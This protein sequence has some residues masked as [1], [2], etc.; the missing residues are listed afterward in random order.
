M[1]GYTNEKQNPPSLHDTEST[2]GLGVNIVINLNG[3]NKTNRPVVREATIAY[4]FLTFHLH[5]L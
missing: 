1:F 5:H 4:L 3:K 2:T